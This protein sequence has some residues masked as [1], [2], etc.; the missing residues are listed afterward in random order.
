MVRFTAAVC[1]EKRCVTKLRTAARETN[2]NL[3]DSFRKWK[4]HLKVYMEASGTTNKSKQR[5]TAIILHCAGP[6]SPR[7]LR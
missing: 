1:G 4:R 3:A 2:G 7:G 6:S 5:L